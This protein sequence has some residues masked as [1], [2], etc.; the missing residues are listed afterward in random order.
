MPDIAPPLEFLRSL[1]RAIGIDPDA[2]PVKSI[3]IT[4]V[5]GDIPRITVERYPTT[6]ELIT[7]SKA[8]RKACHE[9]GVRPEVVVLLTSGMRDDH[10]CVVPS[11][12][13]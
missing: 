10:V 6:A 1:C 5:A 9:L 8:A 4:A 3:T 13:G 2:D 11:D 12:G 7:I